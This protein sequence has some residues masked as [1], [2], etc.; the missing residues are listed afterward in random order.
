MFNVF[1]IIKTLQNYITC[2]LLPYNLSGEVVV[3]VVDSAQHKCHN[4]L[5]FEQSVKEFSC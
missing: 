4:Q 3:T 1:N 5:R 2:K